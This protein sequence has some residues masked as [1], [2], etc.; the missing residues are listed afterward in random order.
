MK[1]FGD[2]LTRH[3]NTFLMALLAA[4]LVLGSQTGKYR[5]KATIVDIPV[6]ETAAEALSALESFRQQRDQ[7]IRADIAALE[8]LIAQETLDEPTRQQAADMLQ[9]IVGKRQLQTSIEGALSGSSLYPCA[10][11]YQGGILTLV[12]EKDTVTERDTALVMTLAAEH[13]G[14][15]PEDVRIICGK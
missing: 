14:I 7:A 5:A 4:T 10:A 11:V 2:L 8:R 1:T 12:T 6:K 3:K 13:G 15:A 9:E